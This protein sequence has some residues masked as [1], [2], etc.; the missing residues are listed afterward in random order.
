MSRSSFAEA[1]A[2]DFVVWLFTGVSAF[3][4]YTTWGMSGSVKE[5]AV[6]VKHLARQNSAYEEEIAAIRT[7]ITTIRTEQM[8]RSSSVYNMANLEARIKAAEEDLASRRNIRWNHPDHEQ[9]LRERI[10]PIE[11]EIQKL[12]A[13]QP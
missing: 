9:F 6:E 4:G 2:R 10:I 13:Q 8:K 12:K 3:L 7:E 5:L 11:H 1:V